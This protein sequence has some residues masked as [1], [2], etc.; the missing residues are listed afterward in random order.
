MAVETRERMAYRNPPP[1]EK[2]PPTQ[3]ESLTQ[4]EPKR[5][6][7]T[8]QCIETMLAEGA[9]L[10]VPER[11]SK[12]PWRW[13]RNVDATLTYLLSPEEISLEHV[14]KIIHG[15]T[16]EW[17]RQTRDK[18]MRYLWL[19]SS[20]ETQSRFP[21]EELELNKPKIQKTKEITVF[22]RDELEFKS[23]HQKNE[24]L[25]RNLKN[26]NTDEEK[27]RI[28]DQV[29]YSFYLE[30]VKGDTPF[31]MTVKKAIV[32]AGYHIRRPQESSL[33][34]GVIKIEEIPMVNI[35]RKTKVGSKEIVLSYHAVLTED[36]EER[37]KNAWRK[38]EDLQK[39]LISPVQQVAGP[40]QQEI[41]STY[42]IEQRSRFRTLGTLLLEF[43]VVSPGQPTKKY[44]KL[45]LEKDDFPV[46]I[47]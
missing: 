7:K 28:L 3:Q 38:R 6:V 2:L 29:P 16:R 42:L 26:A 9:H 32:N 20:A 47:Y 30:N 31:L 15:H 39:F 11:F 34:Y 14:G 4:E 25:L 43:G 46:H 10:R 23:P 18:T 13:E 22:S 33:F 8:I 19:N 21:F 12:V 5:F 17:E 41:P 37:V 35:P 36:Y 24:E 40:E 45:L 27:Q 44:R 1:I